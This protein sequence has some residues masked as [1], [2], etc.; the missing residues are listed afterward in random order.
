M[1]LLELGGLRAC[2]A[3]AG[4]PGAELNLREGKPRG[5]AC[6][7]RVFSRTYVLKESHGTQLQVNI[8]EFSIGSPRIGT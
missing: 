5:P 6:M 8:I 4:P 7:R 2:P 1:G 3:H